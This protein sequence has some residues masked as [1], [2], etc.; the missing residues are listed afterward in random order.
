MIL[1][2]SRTDKLRKIRK[3]NGRRQRGSP[4]PANV[5]WLFIEL[6][7]DGSQFGFQP[8]GP[9]FQFIR[10]FRCHRSNRPGSHSSAAETA[11]GPSSAPAESRTETPAES[12]IVSGITGISSTQPSTATGHGALIFRSSSVQSWHN[13]ASLMCLGYDLSERPHRPP[14]LRRCLPRPD[15]LSSM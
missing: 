11:L 1:Y 12:C 14:P 2:H 8:F 7:P 6:L 10:R 13:I 5:E 3:K 9:L 4:A 15:R